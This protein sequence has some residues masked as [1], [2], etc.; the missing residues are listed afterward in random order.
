MTAPSV[1][2]TQ[3]SDGEQVC[4]TVMSLPAKQH[5]HCV[6]HQNE[7]GTVGYKT[8]VIQ[9]IESNQ[10]DCY[11]CNH[12][13]VNSCITVVD[14]SGGNFRHLNAPIKMVLAMRAIIGR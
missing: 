10:Y 8:V 13:Y 2:V 5:G 12:G 11:Q 6:A 9:A 7:G 3:L 1:V 14:L 4:L